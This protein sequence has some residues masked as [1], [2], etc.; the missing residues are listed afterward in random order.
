MVYFKIFAKLLIERI[1]CNSEFSND[2]PLKRFLLLSLFEYRKKVP[3]YSF[4]TKKNI[5]RENKRKSLRMENALILENNA[6]HV[7]CRHLHFTKMFNN[8]NLV[9]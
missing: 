6:F 8:L 4:C 3:P 9:T 2:F 5:T 7:Q 1:V